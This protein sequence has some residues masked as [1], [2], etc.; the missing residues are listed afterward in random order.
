MILWLFLRLLVSI[1]SVIQN[2]TL[3]FQ[4]RNVCLPLSQY[5]NSSYFARPT[6]L[7]KWIDRDIIYV[8][9]E[10]EASLDYN[11]HFIRNQTTTKSICRYGYH[12][13]SLKG[14]GSQRWWPHFPHVNEIL[15]YFY[16]TVLWQSDIY[17]IENNIPCVYSISI[18]ETNRIWN[19]SLKDSNTQWLLPFINA[20]EDKWHIKV[21]QPKKC[22]EVNILS[23][24]H[25]GSNIKVNVNSE[26]KTWPPGRFYPPI[27]FLHASD[28]YLLGC[29]IL[30]CDPCEW[31]HQGNRMLNNPLKIL[32][33]NRKTS[34]Q[35]LNTAQ[36]IT[37]LTNNFTL[38]NRTINIFN[39]SSSDKDIPPLSNH[40][41]L[42]DQ[43]DSSSSFYRQ[44]SLLRSSDVFITVHGAA[45]VNIAFMKPCSIVIEVFPWIYHPVEYYR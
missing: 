44:V 5:R 41:L 27:W 24:N 3:I 42:I 34:R 11:L 9:K 38:D 10:L 16:S 6:C 37:F 1:G 19:T 15:F 8:R 13:I 36:I 45:M 33:L 17:S 28:S 25:I 14:V 18:G 22:L 30:G 29:T 7:R 4:L 32:I 23:N 21:I 12:S 40:S 43:F 20:L 39:Y 31:H 35:I 26:E 2:P